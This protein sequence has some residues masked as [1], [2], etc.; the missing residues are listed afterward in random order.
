MFPF[1]FHCGAQ[2]S[3][4]QVLL[5]FFFFVGFS[6]FFFFFFL[7][8]FYIFLLSNVVEEEEAAASCSEA[9]FFE[10]DYDVRESI[11]LAHPNLLPL[12]LPPSHENRSI[13][14][15]TIREQASESVAGSVVIGH[16]DFFI[17]IVCGERKFSA[18]WTG[19]MVFQQM[20]NEGINCVHVD[21]EQFCWNMIW[22]VE[23]YHWGGRSPCWPPT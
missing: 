21:G 20:D 17:L 12:K 18:L 22:L 9:F 13:S 5:G 23:F 14:R 2:G 1:F 3:P 6:L 7:L 15:L 8:W 4:R 10:G 19:V 11:K 16:R